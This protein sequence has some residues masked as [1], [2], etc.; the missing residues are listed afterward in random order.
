AD[1]P[2]DEGRTMG[3]FDGSFWRGCLRKTR[4]LML[5]GFVGKVLPENE[6]CPDLRVSLSADELACAA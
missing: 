1:I 3:Y 2:L 6:P 4:G 5:E